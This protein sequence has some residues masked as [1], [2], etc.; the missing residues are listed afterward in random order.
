MS[1]NTS[2]LNVQP[3]I[4]KLNMYDASNEALTRICLNTMD[5]CQTLTAEE[6][7]I[8]SLRWVFAYVLVPA[9]T[10]TVGVL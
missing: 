3:I 6:A 5:S 9:H 2:G 7:S 4:L 10:R 1:L 8:D